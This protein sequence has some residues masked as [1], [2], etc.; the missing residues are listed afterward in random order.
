MKSALRI[1]AG[2]VARARLRERGL[3]PADVLAVPG[4]A[5]GPKGLILNPLDR[6]LFGRWLA[7][8]GAPVHLLGASI[9]AW[10]MA[11]ACLADADAGHRL[12]VVR[13]A[14][15]RDVVA[16]PVPVAPRLG[17]FRRLAEA[18]FEGGAGGGFAE[19]DR[20]GQQQGRHG[21]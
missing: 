13:D 4:A 19:A 16:D 1:L 21:I 7:G 17:L 15:L 18:F 2:P 9:G 5:G 8:E 14:F 20:C 10:R 3:S 6:F 11:S 12:E